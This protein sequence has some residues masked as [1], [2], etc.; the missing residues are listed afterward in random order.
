MKELFLSAILFAMSTGSIEASLRFEVPFNDDW[1]FLKGNPVGAYTPGFNDAAWEA[2]CL[3]HTWNN[4]DG[5]DGGTYYRGPGWYRKAFELPARFEGKSV[6]VKF[7]AAGFVANVYV[8]GRFVERHS[9]GFAAF[10]FNITGFVSFGNENIIAVEV[11]NTAPDS[12]VEFQIPPISADFTMDGGLYRKVSLVFT[13]PV[14]ISLTDYASPGVFIVQK[15]VTD[16]V[17]DILLKTV[18]SNDSK[19]GRD[20]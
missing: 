16:S 4:L 6:F 12:S 5:Q 17:A 1:K 19:Y 18:L 8:N 7:G 13:D 11:D 10:V 20:R 14:H 3:P 15:K 2:V 9:G